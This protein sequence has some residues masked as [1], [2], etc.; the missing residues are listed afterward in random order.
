[1]IAS[2]REFTATVAMAVAAAVA[3]LA[4]FGIQSTVRCSSVVKQD[5]GKSSLAAMWS[6]SVG[7]VPFVGGRATSAPQEFVPAHNRRVLTAAQASI[8]A[9]ASLVQGGEETEKAEPV[10]VVSID[11]HSD[12]DS[13]IV[14]LS[15]GDRLGALLDTSKALKNLGLNVV[16]AQ[17]TTDEASVAKNK[18]YIT[19]S[20]NGNKVENPELLEAIRLTIINNLLKYHPESSE[21]L[22]LGETF[23]LIPPKVKLDVDVA[24]HISVTKVNPK[25]SVLAVETADRPGLL[26]DIVKVVSDISVLIESAEINTEGLVAK[27]QFYVS[28]GGQALSKSL[29]QVLTNC[30]RYHIRKFDSEEESY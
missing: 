19:R 29:E 10:P 23:G 9:V 7:G 12:P 1:V 4:D 21:Q 18:F 17:V 15:F 20:D 24:T 6:S 11:Q 27:D 25:L 14:E 28:Y 26:L 2:Y 22:Y 8:I 13:T 16:K 30:L 5:G 3:S